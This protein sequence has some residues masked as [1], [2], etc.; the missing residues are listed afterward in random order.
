MSVK[1]IL[2]KALREARVLLTLVISGVSVDA[3]LEL[4]CEA[5]RVLG[6]GVEDALAQIEADEHDAVLENKSTDIERGS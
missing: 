2:E 1:E 3:G 5:T 6:D 4:L